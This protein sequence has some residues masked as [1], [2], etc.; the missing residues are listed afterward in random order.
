MMNYGVCL[1]AENPTVIN[2][3]KGTIHCCTYECC[4]RSA[5]L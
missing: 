2:Q 5:G 4:V 3:N 1:F